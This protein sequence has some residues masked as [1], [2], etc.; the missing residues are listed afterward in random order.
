MTGAD[1]IRGDLIRFESKLT[2][3]DGNRTEMNGI[4]EN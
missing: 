4:E 2:G 1:M 3:R